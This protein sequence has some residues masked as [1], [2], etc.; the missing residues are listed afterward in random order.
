MSETLH[1]QFITSVSETAHSYGADINLAALYPRILR[2]L[3]RG[4]TTKS[5]HR[6]GSTTEYIFHVKNDNTP[7]RKFPFRT[8]KLCESLSH[9]SMPLC[10]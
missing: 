1:F 3:G 5:I 2:P 7:L 10:S 9:A 6:K 4:K 8:N